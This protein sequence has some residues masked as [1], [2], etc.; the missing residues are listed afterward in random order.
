MEIMKSNL[1]S[2][3]GVWKTEKL[4]PFSLP[5]EL[6]ATYLVCTLSLVQPPRDSLPALSCLYHIHTPQG[7]ERVGYLE[8]KPISCS[9]LKPSPT[10]GSLGSQVEPEASLSSHFLHPCLSRYPLAAGSLHQL[11]LHLASTIS[12]ACKLH[13]THISPANPTY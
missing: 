8:S 7:G 12:S 9:G 13:P 3:G 10:G 4:D 6:F 1:K 5:S 2:R 11:S